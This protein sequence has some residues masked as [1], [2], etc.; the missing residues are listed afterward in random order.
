MKLDKELRHLFSQFSSYED[1]KEQIVE[2]YI[3][4][5]GSVRCGKSSESA[6]DLLAYDMLARTY[7]K[8]K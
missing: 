1:F 4:S 3:N 2:P 7:F 6:A 5:R 8:V